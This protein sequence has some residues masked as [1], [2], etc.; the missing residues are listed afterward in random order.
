MSVIEGQEERHLKDVEGSLSELQRTVSSLKVWMYLI[1]PKEYILKVFCHY[2]H[3][4]L[5]YVRLRVNA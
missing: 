2:L 3:F 5:N 1:D 4:L